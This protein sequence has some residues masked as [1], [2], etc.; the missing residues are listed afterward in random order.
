MGPFGTNSRVFWYIGGCFFG[1]Y[2][3]HACLST[4]SKAQT[5]VKFFEIKF[6]IQFFVVAVILKHMRCV[7][8]LS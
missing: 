7:T 5:D 4:L 1:T 2:H 3:I 6:Y 8:L